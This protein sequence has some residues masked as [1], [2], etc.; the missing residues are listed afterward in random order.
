MA[1]GAI[2][3]FR[4]RREPPGRYVSVPVRDE[5]FRAFIPAP[6]P[7]QPEGRLLDR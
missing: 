2:L 7:P 5:P 1:S 3:G 4:M 6:L